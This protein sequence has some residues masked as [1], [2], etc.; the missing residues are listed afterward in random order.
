MAMNLKI[1]SSVKFP[2]LASVAAVSLA[3]ILSHGVCFVLWIKATSDLRGFP[4]HHPNQR[5]EDNML[6]NSTPRTTG[7]EFKCQ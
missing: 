7:D 4:P 5:F 2:K 6:C 1:F 3:L